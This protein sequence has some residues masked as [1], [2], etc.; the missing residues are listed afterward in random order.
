MSRDGDG[1]ERL[2]LLD[3]DLRV[4]EQEILALH[5][6]PARLGADEERVVGVLERDLG[7]AGAG[8]AR[9]QGKGAVLELHHHA[10]QRGL[11]LVDR[12]F[13]ELQDDRLVAAEHLAGRDA[14]QERI[15]DLAGGAGDGNSY[16]IFHGQV[17]GE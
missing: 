4:L 2:A 17:P 14:E 10:L 13:E 8:H 15:A 7:I 9:E 12:Q 5:A 6:G 16:G 11:R 3:E 1:V